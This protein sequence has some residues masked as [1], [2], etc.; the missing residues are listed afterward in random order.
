MKSQDKTILGN[1]G[2]QDSFKFPG[3]KTVYRTL[4]Y[5]PS[6]ANPWHGT[7]ECLNLSTNKSEKIACN[8]EVFPVEHK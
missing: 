2:L 4:T 7:R 6:S 3:Q 1:L 8:K 5:G